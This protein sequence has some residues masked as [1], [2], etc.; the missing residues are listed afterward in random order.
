[1]SPSSIAILS[2]I[3]TPIFF[4]LNE[5]AWFKTSKSKIWAFSSLPF[6]TYEVNNRKDS[7]SVCFPIIMFVFD[8]FLSYNKIIKHWLLKVFYD[9]WQ[10]F[11]MFTSQFFQST[12]GKAETLDLEV[13]NDAISFAINNTWVKFFESMAILN[14]AR[15][16]YGPS[17]KHN[18]V[19]TYT[20]TA[21]SHKVGMS[22]GF[23]VPRNLEPYTCSRS[24]EHPSIYQDLVF[25]KRAHTVL[26]RKKTHI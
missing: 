4:I 9:S 17:L 1:M 5:R 8:H 14:N 20:S 3:F 26:E 19:F 24:S 16:S 2:K 22:F 21:F 12:S 11:Q 15:Y 18:R 7:D 6:K 23:P 10:C 13:L 25:E